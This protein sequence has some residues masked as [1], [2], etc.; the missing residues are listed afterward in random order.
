MRTLLLLLGQLPKD[1]LLG[2]EVHLLVVRCIFELYQEGSTKVA[3]ADA[4]PLLKFF[5]V[6]YDRRRCCFLPSSCLLHGWV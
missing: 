6:A 5:L 3:T 1:D 2:D 4:P